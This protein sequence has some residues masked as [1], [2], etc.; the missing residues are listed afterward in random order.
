[1]T[2]IATARSPATPLIQHDPFFSIWSHHD[3]L[4]DGPTRHWTGERQPL[5]GMLRI[6]GASFRFLGPQPRGFVDV[7]AMEQLERRI[8]PLR[9]SYRFAA[10]GVEL[11]LTF[12]SPLLP[13]DL[14]LLG[15]PVTYIDLSVSSSDGR[16][17][18]VSAF[19][20][21]GSALAVGDRE[22]ELTW[23]RHRAGPVEA[24]FLGAAQQ[25]P[26][27]RSADEATIEWGYLFLA[28]Q[29]GQT[30]TGA[31]GDAFTLRQ[32]FLADGTIPERDDVRS[33]RALRMPAISE[34]RGLTFTHDFGSVTGSASWN[35]LVAQD[36]I[37]AVSYFHRKLRPYWGRKGDSAIALIERAWAE[38]DA[39]MAK[40]DAADTQ[41][42][43]ALRTSGGDIYA[44]LG[45]LAFRQGLAAHALVEDFDGR[46]LH[47]SKEN[48]SNGSIGTVDVT[49]PAAPF[50]LHYNPSL[51]EA[52]IY[53]VLDY[54][55]SARWPFDY[56]PHDVGRYPHADGQNYGGG[57]RTDHHQ[58][59]VE[60]CGNLLILVAALVKRTGETRLAEEFFSQLQL[61]AEYLGKY[62]LDPDN[63]LCT[64]D[65]AGHMPHNANLSIKAIVGLGSFAQLCGALGKTDLAE[66][67]GAMAKDWAGQWIGMA[68]DGDHFRLAFDQPGSWSQKYNLVWDR[69]LGL[70]LFPES[71]ATTEM[72][73]YRKKLNRYGL[74]LDSRKDYT[75]L[76]WLVWSACLTGKREDFDAMLAPVA[77]WLDDAP[78]R[79]PLSDWYET[80]S[81]TQPHGHGFFARS[82]VC[83][84]F[85]KL[86]LDAGA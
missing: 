42:V 32:A 58:M 20:E 22:T 29:P 12:T 26:L 47:F 69:Y 63:Q 6:D 53:P 70:G 15:R 37:W 21:A 74:P 33:V 57:D 25:H 76:D 66:R 78:A 56:A 10:A 67:Y 31:F 14:E 2:D 9:T 60:E 28:S 54:A 23:G 41:I 1:M 84:V 82:V 39:V 11:T 7:P 46:L 34:N 64:D 17:H 85:I 18:E 13:D 45:T 86:M 30:A 75:K 24:L 80:D 73:H 77:I 71:V 35:L 51:L 4:T 48:S 27:Q 49:Y 38:R 68:D 19:F 61:W 36:Q 16:P 40:V 8:T 83:G 50:F 52:Q 59:P 72:A 65:F 79:V 62:G 3:Q 5:F 81:G 44:R 43:E 55:R